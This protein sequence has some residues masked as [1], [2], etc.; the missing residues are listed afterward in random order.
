MELEDQL[1]AID[2]AY[3]EIE[4]DDPEIKQKFIGFLKEIH[5][6]LL[7]EDPETLRYFVF[8]AAR[9][10]GGIYIPYLF[11]MELVKFI[12]DNPDEEVLYHLIDCFATS[13]FEEEE[14]KKMKPL[15][16]I[17]FAH[18][19]DFAV[20]RVKSHIVSNSHPQVRDYFLALLR[21]KE[22]NKKSIEAYTH[23]FRLLK[24]Y[25]PNFEMFNLPVSRLEEELSA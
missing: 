17:Y 23:K 14:R 7:S 13:D 3:S 24:G 4:D 1:A 18:Q 22:Q 11:W 12:E 21:F 9:V 15:L 8:D 20:D 19:R 10:A 16:A 2:N 6:E 5:L 25:Y